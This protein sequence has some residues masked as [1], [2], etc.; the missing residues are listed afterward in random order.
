MKELIE[1]LKPDTKSIRFREIVL[2]LNGLNYE[3]KSITK[4][5]KSGEY[6][7]LYSVDSKIKWDLISWREV[8]TIRNGTV[9]TIIKSTQKELDK[10][11]LLKNLGITIPES[12]YEIFIKDKDINWINL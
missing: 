2:D 3:A 9:T 11:I 7:M 6:L 8:Q 12:I 10:I 4:R 1:L 5:H